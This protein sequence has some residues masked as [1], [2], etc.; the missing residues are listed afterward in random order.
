MNE[1][2]S[3]YTPSAAAA[4][5]AHS[6]PVALAHHFPV[7]GHL[8]MLFVLPV[9]GSLLTRHQSLVL[10]DCRA[11][12]R[13]REPAAQA[14]MLGSRSFPHT[15]SVSWRSLPVLDSLRPFELSYVS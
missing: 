6:S 5:F 2:L 15:D 13:C 4:K 7:L 12:L 9:L 1:L 8:A 14:S 10:S 11:R 3:S